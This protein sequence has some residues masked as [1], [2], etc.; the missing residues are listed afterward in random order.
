MFKK[1]W[2]SLLEMILVIIIISILF[3]ASSNL[4]QTPN[5]YILDSEVCINTIQGK[6]SQFFYQGITGK[7]GT[8][9]GVNYEGNNYKFSFEFNTGDM[10]SILL[11]LSTWWQNYMPIE[12][13]TNNNL[14][15]T[16]KIISCDTLTY[17]VLL[18]GSI[19]INTGYTNTTGFSIDINKNLNN[20]LWKPGMRICNGNN[21]SWVFSSKIDYLTCKKTEGVVDM[22]S[23]RHMFSSRFDTA[24]QS[25]K[26][27]RCLN[28]L[29]NQPCTKW[30]VDPIIFNSAN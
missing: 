22:N 13:I 10:Y 28:V 4:F 24:T 2:F 1:S 3:L 7:D 18:S 14:P 29:Y 11:S 5:K 25:L 6:L 30:A 17:K 20:S 16:T 23:C 26:T 8:I 15:N 9:S 19:F 27:N 12:N 21:C